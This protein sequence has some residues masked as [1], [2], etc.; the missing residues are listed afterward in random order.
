MR[1]VVKGGHW[2]NT[3]DEVLKAAVMKYGKN[4]WPRVA[5]LLNRKSAKQCKARWYEWL[6]PSIK[7]TEWTREEEE[8]LLHLAKL[9]PTQ[10]RTIAPIVGRTATQCLEHYEKLLDRAQNLDKD[11]DVSDDPRKL[12]LGEIDPN[13]ESKPARPDAIDLDEDEKEMLSEARARLA[14][15]KGK[16]EKRKAR[17]KQLEEARRIAALQKKRE[18]KAA[19]IH[20]DL[21]EKK[22]KKKGQVIL[23]YNKI[24]P[25]QKSPL[26]GF[27]DINEEVALSKGISMTFHGQ[28]IEEM[29]GTKKSVEEERLKKEDQE[30]AKR[31]RK[32]DLPQLL[33]QMD[34]TE[35]YQKKVKLSLPSPTVDDN[36]LEEVGKVLAK[37]NNEIDTDQVT[38][39]LLTNY[40]STPQIQS[41]RTPA[42]GIDT[43][44]EGA[45]N[46]ATLQKQQTPLVGGSNPDLNENFKDF[47]GIKPSKNVTS[48]PNVFI[49]KTPSRSIL[50][51]PR[52]FT[53]LKEEKERQEILKK[54]LRESIESLPKPQHE[55]Y[56]FSLSKPKKLEKEDIDEDQEDYQE[57]QRKE[58]LDLDQ[59]RLKK[60]SQVFQRKL[61]VPKHF[62]IQ[63]SKDEILNMIEQEM[64]NLIDFDL[65]K[66]KE[67]EEFKVAELNNARSILEKENHNFQHLIPSNYDE[68]WEECYQEIKKSIKYDTPQIPTSVE[69]LESKLKL[70]TNGYVHRESK[71]NE[72]IQKTQNEVYELKLQLE[73]YQYIYNQ[74]QHAI[75]K[76]IETLKE[77]IFF[78][79]EREKQLQKEYS[80][81][82][83]IN[84]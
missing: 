53:S 81:R 51:T 27:Y 32:E 20:Q 79:K 9:F 46:L 44:K 73:T 80:D 14:N 39:K 78:E 40:K 58:E 19:G 41:S 84:Q 15:T 50:S 16:K 82:T 49:E 5:S 54:E 28:T 42:L 61:P 35:Q 23:D 52:E 60:R 72:D 18:L 68:I 37:E 6:D 67:I 59:I 22:K 26:P 38:S 8:R 25:Q 83:K 66:V 34:K 63:K 1:N 45:R 13:P 4:Q 10:W 70:L 57:R 12:R 62:S 36:Q 30:K 33:K 56:F 64:K 69:K 2:K 71:L 65:G 48:T 55:K 29:E 77:E 43:V 76:R 75:P 24:I 3:E 47:Q 74:E 17:E 31:K 11:I 7:K 21:P